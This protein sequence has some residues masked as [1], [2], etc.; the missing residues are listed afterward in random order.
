MKYPPIPI[1]E[2]GE[3]LVPIPPDR[4][5]FV[6][7]HPYVKAGADYKGQSPYFLRQRVLEALIQAQD[8]LQRLHPQWQIQIFDAYRPVEVQQHMVDYTFAEVLRDRGLTPDTLSSQREAEI[9]EQV[10]EIWAVPSFDPAEPPP[11]STGGAVDVT[12]ADGSGNP[13]EMGS[14]IDEL[15]PRSHPDYYANSTQTPDRQYNAHRQL[16]K[17]VMV[18]AGFCRHPRE[19]WHFCLGDRMWA[20]LSETP[21]ARYGRW[22]TPARSQFDRQRH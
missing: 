21:N 14:D 6:T 8:N 4:F 1:V 19:W 2:C 17:T 10:Y 3:P 7:P 12:L 16:L 9:R 22:E 11:H 15:S 20:W 5:A 18:E 13:V